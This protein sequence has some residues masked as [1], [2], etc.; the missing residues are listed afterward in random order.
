[1]AIVKKKRNELSTDSKFMHLNNIN[2]SFFKDVVTN[3][4]C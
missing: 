1:M 2:I 4:D 3:I